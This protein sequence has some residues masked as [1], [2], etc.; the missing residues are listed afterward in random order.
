MIT[1]SHFFAICFC[2]LNDFISPLKKTTEAS[3]RMPK[4]GAGHCIRQH[5]SDPTPACPAALTQWCVAVGGHLTNAGMW[6]QEPMAEHTTAVLG[7][8]MQAPKSQLQIILDFL[9]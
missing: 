9:V 2:E 8:W 5:R 1:H 3:A 7:G 6:E 4:H